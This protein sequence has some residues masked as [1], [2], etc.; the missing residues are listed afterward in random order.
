MVCLQGRHGVSG[1]SRPGQTA[2][3]RGI[4]GRPTPSLP[5]LTG[6]P[7][8]HGV[9]VSAQRHQPGAPYYSFCSELGVLVHFLD[10]GSRSA[11]PPAPGEGRGHAP[12][13]LG[14]A[15]LP[16]C[17]ELAGVCRLSFQQ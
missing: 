4:P 6:G 14:S 12:D 11:S 9:R 10:S 8:V 13:P 1:V 16:G 3:F 15:T 5:G 7:T 2:D 17:T